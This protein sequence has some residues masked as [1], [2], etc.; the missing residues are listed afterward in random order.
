MALERA[1]GGSLLGWAPR[2]WDEVVDLL[3]PLLAGLAHAHA[4]GV[5]HRDLKPANLLIATASDPRPGLK[6]ADFGL[7]SVRGVGTVFRRGLRR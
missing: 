1:S 3:D 2:A 4:H 6:I 7:T 5:L